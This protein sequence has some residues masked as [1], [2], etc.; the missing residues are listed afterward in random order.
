MAL[1]LDTGATLALLDAN[2]RHHLRCVRLVD[3]TNET[4]VIPSATLYELDY[5]VRNR[6][7]VEV[8]Q[9]FAEDVAAG[10]YRLEPVTEADLLRSAALERQYADADLDFVD[11]AVIALCE[12]LGEPKVATLDRR[13]FAIVRPRHVPS[14][15]LLPY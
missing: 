7:T 15:E 5:W 3:E 12:R 9:T 4:L 8:W 11:A 1:I 13:D 10:G 6:L 14:L 2:D